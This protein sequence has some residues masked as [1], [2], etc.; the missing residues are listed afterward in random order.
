MTAR[1]LD[2]ENE[3]LFNDRKD[4]NIITRVLNVKTG[5]E[6]AFP[7]AIAGVTWSGRSVSIV[8]TIIERGA[9]GFEAH[10]LAAIDRPIRNRFRR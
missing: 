2:P 7:G 10:A 1:S 3:I 4:G 9:S 5:R 8:M 6:N